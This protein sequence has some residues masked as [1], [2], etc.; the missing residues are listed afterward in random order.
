VQEA[1]AH[2]DRFVGPRFLILADRRR[3]A[4]L[5]VGPD[6]RIVCRTSENGVLFHTNHYVEDDLRRFNPVKASPKGAKR[7]GSSLARYWRI[8]R[9]VQGVTKHGPD[10]FITVAGSTEDG[11]SHS[12]WRSGAGPKSPRTLS[13]WIVHNVKGGDT[14][15]YVKIRNPDE[16]VREYRLNARDVFKRKGSYALTPQE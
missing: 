5:E 9:Y 14:K 12:L 16:A 2:K 8:S 4:L 11:P 3:I 10:D 13:T 7:Y 15:I 6:R 1:L